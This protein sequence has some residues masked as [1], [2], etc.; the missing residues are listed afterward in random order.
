MASEATRLGLPVATICT[1]GVQIKNTNLPECSC[2]HV[3]IPSEQRQK[4]EEERKRKKS[5]LY[6]AS[7]VNPNFRGRIVISHVRE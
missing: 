2:P 6:D 4:K 5:H 3:S 1:T 7:D